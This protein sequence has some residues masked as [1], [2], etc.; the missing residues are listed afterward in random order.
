MREPWVVGGL[1]A[2]PAR[3]DEVAPAKV[4]MAGQLRAAGLVLQSAC[5]V[6]PLRPAVPVHEGQGSGIR[7]ALK[8]QTLDQPGEQGWGVMR[9]NRRPE[10]PLREA[11]MQSGEV[12]GLSCKTTQADKERR[13]RHSM[14]STRHRCT[15]YSNEACVSL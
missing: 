5:E 14:R 11:L 13:V 8:A 3:A 12:A 4:P 9:P 2:A 15:S 1:G 7:D 10:A 6:L